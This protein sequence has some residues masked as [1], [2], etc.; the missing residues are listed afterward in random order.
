MKKTLLI[1]FILLLQGIISSAQEMIGQLEEIKFESAAEEEHWKKGQKSPYDLFRAVHAEIVHS[2]EKWENLILELDKRH[3]KKGNSLALLRSIFEKSHRDLFKKYEQHSSFNAMLTEGKFDCVSGSAA[4]GLLLDR[5]RFK[6]EI[7]ETDFHVFIV[8]D[9]DGKNIIFES[10]LPIGGL[11]TSQSQ[12]IAYL[13]SYK[14]TKN[15]QFYTLNQRLGDPNTVL[16]DRSIFRKVSLIQLAGLQYYNDA[17]LHFNEQYFSAASLQL[18]KALALYP[19][20][21]IEG[22]KSLAIEQAYKTFGKDI[23]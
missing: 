2:D 4:L 10:T 12:V 13:E 17:I 22:L 23:K 20:P 11:I 9:H 14:P 6:F 3:S 5:Y 21:R 19:S 18:N 8:I 15:A 16:E 1:S 7:I